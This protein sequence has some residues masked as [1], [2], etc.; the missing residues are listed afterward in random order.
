MTSA[1]SAVTV[2]VTARDLAEDGGPELQP[3]GILAW[4]RS[5]GGFFPGGVY[6]LAGDAGIGKST[7]SIEL[8]QSALLL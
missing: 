5:L 7:L 2:P 8:L 4:D 6:L 1:S 3:S